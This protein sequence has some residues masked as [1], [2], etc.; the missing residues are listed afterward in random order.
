MRMEI[1]LYQ[2]QP[3]QR[4]WFYPF[5][6][7]PNKPT[8]SRK[9]DTMYAWES[10]VLEGKK[11]LG[12]GAVCRGEGGFVFLYPWPPRKWKCKFLVHAPFCRPLTGLVEL[13]IHA[14]CTI[15]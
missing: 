13:R 10:V 12:I 5:E 3:P 15:G 2:Y 14:S 11:V 4:Q 8:G 6:Q 1:S 9:T 7:A